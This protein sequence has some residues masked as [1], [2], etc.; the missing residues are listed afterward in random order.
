LTQRD[1][2]TA[3]SGIGERQRDR[4]RAAFAHMGDEA[5]LPAVFVD[6]LAAEEQS[7]AE[8]RLTDRSV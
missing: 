4:E 5:D 1:R 7:K 2:S 8:S 3:P 6:E